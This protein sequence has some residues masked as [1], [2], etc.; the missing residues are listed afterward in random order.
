MTMLM[1]TTPTIAVNKPQSHIISIIL[2]VVII[3]G[4]SGAIIWLIFSIRSYRS[5]ITNENPRCPTLSCGDNAEN[6]D[7]SCANGT[8]QTNF[9]AYRTK[10][11]GTVQ[12]QTIMLEPWLAKNFNT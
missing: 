2:I 4:I 6:T 8:N 7:P 5:W 10:S 11:D 12:C 9:L 3:V 1:T